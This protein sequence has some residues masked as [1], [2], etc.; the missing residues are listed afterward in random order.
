MRLP[1]LDDKSFGSKI[2]RTESRKMLRLAIDRG[3]NYLD[4]AYG[5]HGGKS[6]DFLGKALKGAYREKVRVATKSPIWLIKKPKDFDTH[7]NT[8]LKRLGMDSIDFYLF[9]GLS[10]KSWDEVVVKNKL[11]K[12][13]EAAQKAGKIKEIGFSFHDDYDAFKEIVDG[14]PDWSFCQIQ[15]NY[16]DIENQAGT[17]GL[18]YAARK[19]MA[20]VV[21]EPLLGGRLANPPKSVKNM[22]HLRGKKVV[23]FELAL[24]WVWDQPEVSLLL[25]G[26]SSMTHVRGNLRVAD[27]A[28][29]GGLTKSEHALI[30]RIRKKYRGMVPIP[31]TKCGYCMPCP[32]GVRIPVNFEE[33]NEAF[34]HDDVKHARLIYS[35]FFNKSARADACKK[36]GKCVDKCPQKIPIPDMLAKVHSVLGEGK[37]F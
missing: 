36:C 23:P 6:E 9:H 31:C 11:I 37:P 4:T 27:H 33:Y 5:Y 32:H 30:D 26:M 29:V 3:V 1:T 13:A 14:Y 28:V 22:F 10:K 34:I 35:R 2:D 25:S 21:M 16:M 8:Q 20:V 17:K 12:R 7:L 24:R 18:R 15:Y 19:G